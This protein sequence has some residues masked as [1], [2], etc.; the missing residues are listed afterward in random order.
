MAARALRKTLPQVVSHIT[1]L[2][3]HAP[4]D[5]TVEVQL[6]GV[7]CTLE[8]LSERGLANQRV[9]VVTKSDADKDKRRTD[10]FLLTEATS[11]DTSSGQAEVLRIMAEERRQSAQTIGDLH[12]V[13]REQTEGTL[14]MAKAMTKMSKDLSKSVRKELK[15]RRKLQEND[16]TMG[17]V[18]EALR[19]ANEILG[20]ERFDK[21]AERLVSGVENFLASARPGGRKG[22]SEEPDTGQRPGGGPDDGEPDSDAPSSDVPRHAADAESV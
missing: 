7:P 1:Q 15:A 4:E 19:D 3:E 11:G 20:P 22:T 12:R 17:T 9:T 5:C 16:G 18:V 13:I 8:D 10:L 21:L 6:D 14:K 2:I